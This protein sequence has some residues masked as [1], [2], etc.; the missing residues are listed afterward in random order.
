MNN[1]SISLA[2]RCN[3]RF[4]MQRTFFYRVCPALLLG[5]MGLMALILAIAASPAVAALGKPLPAKLIASPSTFVPSVKLLAIT[6]QA[7]QTAYRISETVL[8][9]GTTVREYASPDGPVFAITWNGPLLPELGTLLGDHFNS[10][11]L[12]ASRVRAEGRRGSPF[13]MS[14]DG[15]VVRSG[16]RMGSFTGY[17]YVQDLVP[18]EV[19]INDVIQ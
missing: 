4:R 9:G 1:E 14:R 5:R 11:S 10:F 2:L 8:E 7:G 12:E 13:M 6:S 17:A 18:A 19:N 3:I 15:L 16:G